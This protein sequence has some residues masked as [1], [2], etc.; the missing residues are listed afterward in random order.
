VIGTYS[1]IF[2]ASPALLAIQQ[3]WPKKQKKGGSVRSTKT[4]RVEAAV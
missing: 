1:S 4:K 3:R 2:V